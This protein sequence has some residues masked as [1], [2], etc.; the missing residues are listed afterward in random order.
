M[1]RLV[2]IMNGQVVIAHT[3][4]DAPGYSITVAAAAGGAPVP[5]GWTYYADDLEL[6]DFAEPWVPPTGGTSYAL[7]ALVSHASKR[8]RSTIIGNVWEPGVSG[9]RE[10]DTDVPAWLQPTGAHDAY[11]LDAL[12]SRAGKVWKSL[13]PANVWQPPTNWRESVLIPPSGVAPAPAWV[14]PTGAGD[15]YAL[16]ALV[17]HA[18][19]TWVSGYAANVWEPGVFGWTE[20]T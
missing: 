10:A 13:V 16:G 17:T 5:D 6:A 20:T 8:W 7:G 15:A 2:K 19:K 11:A 14:Q 18:G 1:G 9:W 12:V 3:R 4:V